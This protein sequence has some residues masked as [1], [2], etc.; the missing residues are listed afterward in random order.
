AFPQVP[1]TIATPGG[2]YAAPPAQTLGAPPSL[3]I[4]TFPL[5]GPL[6][7]PTGPAEKGPRDGLTLDQTIKRLVSANLDL[8]ARFHEIPKAQA[9]VLT[10]GLRANPLLFFDAQ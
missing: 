6:E 10:A 9:D 7:V 8:R 2:G 5:Y 3:P 4:S 1:A